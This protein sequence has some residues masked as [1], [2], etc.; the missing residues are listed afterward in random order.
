[1]PQPG[2]DIGNVRRVLQSVRRSRRTQGVQAQTIEI[3]PSRSP[4][5]LE[6]PLDAVAGD[7]LV[8]AASAVVPH[9]PKL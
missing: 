4:V 1:M 6:H 7:C 8:L 5:L 2:L 3:D 9:L